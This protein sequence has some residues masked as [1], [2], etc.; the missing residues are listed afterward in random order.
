MGEQ[1]IKMWGK[2][3]VQR[4]EP[5]EVP[6]CIS[7]AQM[8]ILNHFLILLNLLSQIWWWFM[9]FE[10]NQWHQSHPRNW[11]MRWDISPL[12]L[13]TLLVLNEVW[14]LA[15]Q[16]FPVV[17]EMIC[18]IVS[19]CFYVC[20]H[21]SFAYYHLQQNKSKFLDYISES[22]LRKGISWIVENLTI[23]CLLDTKV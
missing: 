14:A 11:N 15:F 5:L 6:R 10:I 19:K 12:L 18:L 20:A 3:G 4:L 17:L 8:L 7:Y 16:A 2:G 1:E 22:F 13:A 23:S 9:T 21:K